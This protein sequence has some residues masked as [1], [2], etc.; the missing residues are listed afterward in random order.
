MR[1]ASFHYG[2]WPLETEIASFVQALGWSATFT[3]LWKYI[4][5][6]I[7]LTLMGGFVQTKMDNVGERSLGKT[8]DTFLNDDML[9]EQE[10]RIQSNQFE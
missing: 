1:A 10:V 2:G 4:V 5:G 6:T 7:A 3:D 9:K 8:A